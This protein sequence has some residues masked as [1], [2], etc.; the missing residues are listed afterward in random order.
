M[1]GLGRRLATSR[2]SGLS[3]LVTGVAIASRNGGVGKE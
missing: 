2:R 3:D 1:E